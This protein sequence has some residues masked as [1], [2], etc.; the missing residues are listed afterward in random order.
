[1][2]YHD[3]SHEQATIRCAC[4]DLDSPIDRPSIPPAQLFLAVVG[5]YMLDVTSDR[6]LAIELL[7][8]MAIAVALDPEAY[9]RRLR[10]RDR[11]AADEPPDLGN[12]AVNFRGEKSG[13]ATHRSLTAPGC[14]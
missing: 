6:T 4:R 1:M 10:A 13:N 3:N 12:R 5:G 14:R 8:N 2:R 11:D 7:C 9:K